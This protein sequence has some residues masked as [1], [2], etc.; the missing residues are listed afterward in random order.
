MSEQQVPQQAPVGGTPASGG[1]PAPDFRPRVEKLL[2][3]IL[4]LMGFPARLDMQDAADGSLSVALH[5]EAGPP[6]GVEQGRRSQVLDSLQFLLNKMLH[7][8]GVERRWVVL[9]CGAHPEPRQ[10]REPQQ[11][12]PAQ[13]PAPVAGA[14]AAPAPAPAAAPRAPAPVAQSQAPG[15]QAQRGA[16]QAAAPRSAAA[17]ARA[18]GESDERSVAV[19]ED[20][21]LREAVRRLAEK[22]A[23]LGRFYALAAMKQDD[24]ARVLKAVEGV[25]GL[26]VTAEGEGRNRRVVFTP[27]KPAPLPKRSLLP[28]DDEDDFDE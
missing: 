7:R 15:K 20:A 4:G 16:A 6:P 21:A 5:F 19:E 25:A 1:T 17:P 18:G 3:D 11:Q 8:P 23:S 22:S 24:R 28:D 27:E 10:R 2:G 9:G 14:A 26:K 12:A 13:A